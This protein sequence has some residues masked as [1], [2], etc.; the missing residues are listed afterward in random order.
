MEGT[1]FFGEHLR[2]NLGWENLNPAGAFIACFI[3]L[4]WGLSFLMGS[5]NI[6]RIFFVSLLLFAELSLWFLLCKTYS[7]GA[8]V[9]IAASS[10]IFFLWFE[11]Q[12][13]RTKKPL[14]L[15]R[16][17]R[18]RVLTARI[19]GVVGLLIFTGFIDRIEPS[20]VGN[21][22]SAG[23]RLTLWKGGLQMIAVEP[24]RGWGIDQS[25]IAFMHWFQPLDE[26][27]EYAR[28]FG[29]L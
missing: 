23:N 13:W 15:Q 24:W 27:A 4:L 21:D 5:K 22:A 14:D 12:A 8:L 16:K 19:L 26:T 29:W 3:P 10:L 17:T 2:W 1:F 7:R 18:W 20:Y 25:G 9:A 28:A 11:F 6:G